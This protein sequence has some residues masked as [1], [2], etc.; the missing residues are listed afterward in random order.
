MGLLGQ[1]TREPGWVLTRLSCDL[2]VAC[3]LPDQVRL[4][5]GFYR[6]ASEY[7]A[8]ASANVSAA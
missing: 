7:A 4:N 8:R 5:Q 6:M 2:G 3:C 1:A